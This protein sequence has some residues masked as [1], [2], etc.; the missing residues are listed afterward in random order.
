MPWKEESTMSLRAEFLQLALLP[1]ANISLLARRFGISRKTAYKWI[2]RTRHGLPPTDQSRKPRSS[3]RQTPAELEQRVLQLR[4]RHPAWGGRKLRAVLRA[5]A[6]DQPAPA[7][8]TITAILRRHDRLDGPRAGAPRDWQRFEHP[9]PNDLWQMDF[10]GHFALT[11]GS[12]CHPLTV[13]DDHSRF[14]LG[15]AACPDERTET[16]QGALRDIFA[17]HGLPSR[18]LMDNGSPWGDEGGQ[19][20]TRLTVWLLRLGIGV[21]HGRPYHPQTQGK[22]E[23]FHRTLQGELLSR[24]TFTGLAECAERFAGW[25][26]VYNTVRPHEALGLVAP[27]TRYRPSPRSYV[28]DPPAFGYAPGWT[29]RQV[30]SGGW[31]SVGGQRYRISK[32]F[33]GE[34]LGVCARTDL[35]PP[36]T[37]AWFGPHRLGVLCPHRQMLVREPQPG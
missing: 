4:A 28:A 34:A 1:E 19:P 8:S 37:E 26:A 11:D 13:L 7:P 27:V 36:R 15:L 9:Q 35:D 2:G 20:Y 12:R 23:R 16:V 30:A 33:A 10:K 18:M 17:R 29:I 31:V 14:A 22:D 24:T 32:A 3:P 21:C 5:E 25:R 6:P